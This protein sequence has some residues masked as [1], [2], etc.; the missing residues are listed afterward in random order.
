MEHSSPQQTGQPVLLAA[1][2]EHLSPRDAV[3][4][5]LLALRVQL[6]ENVV[7]KKHG[8]LPRRVLVDF[9]FRQLQRQGGGP[10]LAL[11]GIGLCLPSVNSNEKIVL[12]GPGQAQP[13]GQLRFPVALHVPPEAVRQRAGLRTGVLYGGDR[14]IVKLQ[15]F[16]SAGALPVM[17]GGSSRQLP[18]C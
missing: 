15:P 1:G 11:G 8:I 14:L 5:K 16:P 13:G 7:Q 12:M 9:S 10:G 3:Q 18:L 17:D 2:D 6:A 4:D